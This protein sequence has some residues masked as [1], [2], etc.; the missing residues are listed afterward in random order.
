MDNPNQSPR[1][2]YIPISEEQRRFLEEKYK[3]RSLAPESLLIRPKF[4]VLHVA[5]LAL[6]LGLGGYFALY[7][8]FG[9]KETC[10]TP[11]TIGNEI[12]GYG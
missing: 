4:R 5:T 10:F 9:D 8:D 11:V 1:N 12:W 6:A 2:E 3:R 7:A